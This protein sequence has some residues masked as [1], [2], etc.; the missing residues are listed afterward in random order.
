MSAE[1][2]RTGPPLNA[3]RNA[4][5]GKTASRNELDPA[6]R[7]QRALELRL[8]GRMLWEIGDELGVT[9]S[10]VSR[11]LT[12][13]LEEIEGENRESAERLRTLEMVRLEKI[14][15]ALYRRSLDGE[16]PAI[17]RFLKVRER[18]AKLLGLDV[19]RG[20]EDRGGLTIEVRFPW[21]A[22]SGGE[23]VDGEASEMDGPA[24]F[25]PEPGDP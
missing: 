13:A 5:E 24:G 8:Q 10:A 15:E 22:G 9:E 19:D 25:L 7:R 17:D 6:L 18:Y 16:L 4:L 3:E 1:R 20:V 2:R 14:G 23:V 11:M 12:K 21:E